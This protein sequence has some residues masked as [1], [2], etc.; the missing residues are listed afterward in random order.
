MRA[1]HSAVK[2]LLLLAAAVLAWPAQAAG[3]VAPAGPV[4]LTVSGTITVRN[5]GDTAVFDIAALEALPKTEIRTTTPWTDAV[6]FEGVSLADLLASVGATGST[7]KATALNDY[8]VEIPTADA[9]LGVVI[10]YRVDGKLLSVRDKGPL[11]IVYPFDEN[12]ALMTETN[13]ARCI[14]QLKALKIEP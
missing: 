7:I 14:W 3:L 2:A 1:L 4:V 13:Y 6:A 5:S 11:W 10:A 8:T 12:P 9:A